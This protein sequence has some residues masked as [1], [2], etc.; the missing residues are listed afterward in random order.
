MYLQKHCGA[1]RNEFRQCTF[2]YFF[3][4]FCSGAI[5]R[6]EVVFSVLSI[7]ALTFNCHCGQCFSAIKKK[8]TSRTSEQNNMHSTALT[9]FQR[10]SLFCLFYLSPLSFSF[11]LSVPLST[12]ESGTFLNPEHHAAE[13]GKKKKKH[14]SPP[15]ESSGGHR[16]SES[17]SR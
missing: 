16:V 7:S 14:R 2:Y 1:A 4:F 11:L 8:K 12:T 17:C 15:S 6:K 10:V 5:T 13:E 3:F 9:I